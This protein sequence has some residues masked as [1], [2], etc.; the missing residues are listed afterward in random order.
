MKSNKPVNSKRPI[1]RNKVLWL[2]VVLLLA[3]GGGAGW[4]FLGV[5]NNAQAQSTTQS[6]AKANTTSVRVGS[7]EVSASGS[8]TLVASQSVDLSFSTGGTVTELMVKTGDTVKAGDVLARLGN[9]DTLQAAVVS[10]QLA[11][12]QAQKTLTDLQQNSSVA[13]AQAYQGWATAQA[14]YTTAQAASQRTSA[15]ARCSQEVNTKYKAALD[16]AT[17]NLANIHSETL[18]D[19]A[20]INA[21]NDYATALANYTYCI[22]YTADEKTSAQSSLAV[23]QAA[24]TQAEQKYN[25]LKTA[26]GIDPTELALDEAKVTTA[27]TQLAQAQQNLAGITLTAPIDGKVV[28]LAASQGAIVSTAK[29][30][31]IADVSHPTVTVSVDETDMDKLKV[32]ATAN[33]SFDALPDQVFTGKVVQVDPQLT[34]SGQVRVATGKVQLDDNT[35]KTVQALPLGLNATV[36]VISQ[37]AQNVLLVPL[38]ALKNLGNQQYA[39]MVMGSDG[40][41]KLQVVTVGIQDATYAEISSGLKAGDVVSTG[42]VQTK[43]STTSSSTSSSTK[44]TTTT[45]TGAGGPPLDAGGI[46]PQ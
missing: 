4:Y 2:V 13:L 14:T 10:A 42:T 28:Y 1:W 40:Q 11:L 38:T 7:I 22:S 21:K 44:N 33:V 39:V 8:G 25:T 15:S 36:T 41:L 29:F 46:P 37:Q 23:A 18:T 35:V 12:L 6:T 3:G 16:R 26:S 20:Y 34:T 17:Q 9:S 24:V 27:Q 5:T 32:G 31:T 43:N 30:I 19:P 45:N